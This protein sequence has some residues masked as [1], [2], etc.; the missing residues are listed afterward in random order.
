MGEGFQFLDIILFAM[1][2]GFIFLRLRG[3]LGRRTGH[4]KPPADVIARRRA[5]DSE[6]NVVQ[7]P[8]AEG[9]AEEDNAEATADEGE[10]MV[11]A[12][13][14]QIKVADPSFKK[15]DF[16]AGARLAYEMI[17]TSFANGDTDT[18]RPLLN[19]E[20][21]ED[22]LAAIRRRERKEE[23]LETT[24]LAINSTDVIEARMACEIA[25]VTVKFV[26]EMV[27]LTLDA[28]GD[29]VSGDPRAVQEIT[30]IWT[31]AR[32][33]AG[34]DPNWTLIATRSSN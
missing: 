3:V 4:E 24:L 12:G 33:L 16:L 7:L 17:V 28:Q 27:N 11:T 32:D 25:E 2:A 26:I 13:L 19:D 5:E 20:V 23:T 31:F 14:A 18:L 6:D 22:F 21:Y 34:R 29:V 15:G 1:V 8:D 30:D 9:Q 10:V